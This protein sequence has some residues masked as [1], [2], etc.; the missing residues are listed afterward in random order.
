MLNHFQRCPVA[1]KCTS[2][3]Q[4]HAVSIGARL[5]RSNVASASVKPIEAIAV[6]DFVWAWD[7]ADGALVKRRVQR[8]F[9]RRH[10]AI[11]QVRVSSWGVDQIVEATTEHPFWVKTKGWVA[12]R[13]LQEGD[14]LRS[15]DDKAELRVR[16]IQKT[17]TVADV[18][19]FE[20]EGAHNYFVAHVG[21]L[22]HNQSV[23]PSLSNR[24]R[25][26]RSDFGLTVSRYE[27][28]VTLGVRVPNQV[29]HYA[30]IVD[31]TLPAQDG[32]GSQTPKLDDARYGQ[33]RIDNDLRDN[34]RPVLAAGGPPKPPGL[35][36]RL[37]AWDGWS[38]GTRSSGIWATLIVPEVSTW[39]A[40]TDG[41]DSGTR[42]S[43][44]GNGLTTAHSLVDA[45]IAT[46]VPSSADPVSRHM[47]RLDR[48]STG[49]VG[50]AWNDEGGRF[51]AV[52][53]TGRGDTAPPG[54]AI[55]ISELP[56]LVRPGTL[57]YYRGRHNDFRLRHPDP[58]VAAPE[59]YLS[60][61]EKY[62]QRFS[63]LGPN[64]LSPAGLEWRDK[65]LFNLQFAIE[66][67]RALN[68]LAFARLELD[69]HA[70]TAFAYATHPQA[71]VD[72]GLLTLP[73][74]DLVRIGLTPDIRDLATADG[75]SQIADVLKAVKPSD[76][77]TIGRKTIDL[78]RTWINDRLPFWMRR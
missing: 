42:S 46:G 38:L 24:L 61:G 7:E 73:A 31:R 55:K 11:L 19:N 32:Q 28:M 75:L 51:E 26:I 1:A 2:S 60:Y 78:G 68:P 72:A 69:N 4:K 27:L 43:G 62:A 15:F 50:N 5:A 22:V 39:R 48:L 41:A 57:D 35:R 3:D 54:G 36:I 23:K 70:F 13:D 49:V 30:H 17:D 76:T 53:S 40:A 74:T 67:R 10:K 34:H 9:R 52:S 44:G 71:Y 29:N 6:G 12:A 8:L 18:F 21:V 59:Y 16:G 20:V 63:S 33:S 64:D 45:P 56:D 66:G 47:A 58:R 65:T 37:P 25:E 14:L 77:V